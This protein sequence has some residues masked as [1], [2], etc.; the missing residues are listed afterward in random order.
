MIPI[1]ILPGSIIV[2]IHAVQVPTYGGTLPYIL[3][4]PRVRPTPAF[5]TRT[6]PQPIELQA[7]VTHKR[8]NNCSFMPSPI[9]LHRRG[10]VTPDGIDAAYYLSGPHG[11]LVI[12]CLHRCPPYL[13]EEPSSG[14]IGNLYLHRMTT[15]DGHSCLCQAVPPAC[16]FCLSYYLSILIP[17][18]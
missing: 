3:C 17:R 10:N 7:P 2:N 12:P 8:G 5:P 1:L 15:L 14:L 16:P 13:V 18:L 9:D 6:L 11:S 4:S